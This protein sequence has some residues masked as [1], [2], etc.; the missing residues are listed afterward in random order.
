[1]TSSVMSSLSVLST[2]TRKERSVKKGK[3]DKQA[4]AISETRSFACKVTEDD[5][6]IVF[7][8]SAPLE[9]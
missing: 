6:F 8:G 4:A 1:M 3:S 9:F 7:K 2:V 5:E